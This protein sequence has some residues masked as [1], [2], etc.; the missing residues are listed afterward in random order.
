MPTSKH[1]ALQLKIMHLFLQLTHSC[2]LCL[3]L[4][5]GCSLQEDWKGCFHKCHPEV[6]HGQ[7]LEKAVGSS[8]QAGHPP[9]KALVL[10]SIIFNLQNLLKTHIIAR[11]VCMMKLMESILSCRY[12]IR[13]KR[14]KL[15]ISKF[16]FLKYRSQLGASGIWIP[17]F[18][19]TML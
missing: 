16:F 4:L 14:V 1:Q 10:F 11:I 9:C 5:S 2:A 3:K 19:A 8:K 12:N 17:D 18:F 15:L 13:H 7:N 6:S